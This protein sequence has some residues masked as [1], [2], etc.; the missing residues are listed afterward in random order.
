MHER[1]T[2]LS[3]PILFYAAKFH[4]A[5]LFNHLIWL[6]E[7]RLDRVMVRDIVWVW[8]MVNAKGYC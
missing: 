3:G 4:V 6:D 5:R 8:T 2:C 7:Y 1:V